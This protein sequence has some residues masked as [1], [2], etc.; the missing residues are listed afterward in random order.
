MSCVCM[1]M[2][3]AA[4]DITHPKYLSPVLSHLAPA[5]AAPRPSQVGRNDDQACILQS[6]I[7]ETDRAIREL[8]FDSTYREK[9]TPDGGLTFVKP[10]GLV[11]P[12]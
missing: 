10:V 12:L 6:L 9:G 7:P 4:P 11:G 5:H 1:S 8:S 2:R 3:S